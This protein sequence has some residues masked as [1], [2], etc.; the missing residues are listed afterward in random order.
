VLPKQ[1]LKHT[2]PCTNSFTTS[3]TCSAAVA[4]DMALLL[5]DGQQY[6]KHN[7]NQT[8]IQQAQQ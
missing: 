2:Q 6:G 4:Q 1:R 5:Q 3:Q 8:T 7:N